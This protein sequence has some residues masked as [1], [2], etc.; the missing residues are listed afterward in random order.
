M[1]APVAFFIF[2]RPRVTAQ[3]FEAIAQAR[4]SRLLVVADGPRSE[5]PDDAQLVAETREV[6]Q[7]VDWPCEV[8][9]CFAEDN[10][11]CG[12]RFATGLDWVFANAS[13]AVILED[14]C[15]PD[16]SFFR[17]C[18]ELLERYRAD[19]RVHMV[20]GFS[21]LEPGRFGP[22]SYYFSR[23][24]HIWGWATWA[25][26]WQSYDF[27]MT[28]WPELR[29]TRWLERHLHSRRAAEIAR[30]L[31]DETYAGRIRQ[32]DFQWVLSGWLRDAVSATPTVN[33][34]RN[35]GFGAGAT[36]L[37]DPNHP[38]AGRRS[39]PM[40]FP[41]RH[42]PEVKVLEQADRAEWKSVFPRYPQLERNWWRRPL[43]GASRVRRGASRRLRGSGSGPAATR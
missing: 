19:E 32:W 28:R 34:V 42:P 9:T 26:A 2:N 18:D 25:R 20:S 29:N 21:P 38:H 33:L 5:H 43:A 13:E 40:T 1:R 3:V 31:F 37:T 41:L 8:L 14:D 35:L 4:P 22:D 15:L 7:H 6:V 16:P 23:C 10:L 24:Y 27:E 36:H 11:G 12:A 39:M 17:Y 30:L